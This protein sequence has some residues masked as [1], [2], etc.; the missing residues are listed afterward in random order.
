MTEEHK[1]QSFNYKFATNAIH[2]G[3]EPEQ[4]DSRCV[5]PR[6]FLLANFYLSIFFNMLNFC[7]LNLAL[8]MSTTFKQYSPAVTAGYDYG[9]SG[10]PTSKKLK[11]SYL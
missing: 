9:R 10:N 2:A 11:F 4:W 8:V 6:K 1:H 3:Q 5:V 7:F